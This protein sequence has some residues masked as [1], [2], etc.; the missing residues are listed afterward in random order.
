MTTRR[1]SCL[2]LPSYAVQGKQRGFRESAALREQYTVRRLSAWLQRVGKQV[3]RWRENKTLGPHF[4]VDD[5]RFCTC[6]C[7]YLVACDQPNGA[8]I[9]VFVFLTWGIAIGVLYMN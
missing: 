3:F 8:Y 6:V 1:N 5:H 4:I 9:G 7:L 2:P